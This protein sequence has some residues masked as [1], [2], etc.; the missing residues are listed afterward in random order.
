[1]I[2]ENH[3]NQTERDLIVAALTAG[4]NTP[5]S[6]FR[7]RQ[8]FH[9]LAEHG[10]AVNEHKPFFEKSCGLPSPFKAAAR[11][12]ALFNSRHA[13]VVWVGKELV[14]GYMTF[15][16]LLKRPRVIDVDDAIWL[17]RPFGRFAAPRIARAMDAAIVGNEYLA[18]WFSN[19]CAQVF[20]VPTAIDI[21]H[22][23]PAEETPSEQFTIGWTGIARNY[24]FLDEIKSALG[25]FLHAHP[26]AKLVLVSNRPWTKHGLPDHQVQFIPW[27]PETEVTGLQNASVGI[28][29]LPDTPWTRGKCSFKMLQ[30][31]AVGL[32]VIVSAVG[33]NRDVLAKGQ[34]GLPAE[35]AQQWCE[36][37]ETFYENRELG[38]TM[39]AAGRRV[40]EEHFNSDHIADPTRPY[41]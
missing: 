22:Y 4:Q 19:Y 18:D 33:M 40:V 21:D 26:D 16:R 41:L 11:I 37:L 17:S 20:V 25:R 34:V 32:P 31:M 27:S 10:I 8:H 9:R 28:M 15:E 29:P 6:R 12:P 24:C 5:S 36:G 35:S 38:H 23:R 3:A 30:Y 2:S 7:M 14:Q 13:D 1:M 39:G